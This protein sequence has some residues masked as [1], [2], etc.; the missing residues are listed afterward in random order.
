MPNS[1]NP[2]ETR[3]LEDLWAGSFGNDY[4]DRNREAGKRRNQFWNSLL[5]E[6]PARRVLEVGCNVGANLQYI[7]GIVAPEGV[8]GVDINRKALNE[9]R[10]NLPDINALWCP[11]RELPFRCNWFDLVLTVGVLIHQPESTLPRAMT[12]VVRCSRRY[13]LCAEYYAEQT[14]EIR[15]RGEERAL[16]KRDYG[17]I[18]LQ[19]FP[20]LFLKKQGFL[21]RDEGWDDVTYWLFEKP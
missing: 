4:T 12:E 20:E 9:L 1:P 21:S 8:Y 13:I 10:A 3:R 2:D 6:F 18:Y 5:T 19:M 17:A 14:T 16:F 15:Y 7:A 11:A